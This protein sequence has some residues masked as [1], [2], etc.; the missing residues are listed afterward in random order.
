MD[1]ACK[2]KRA[3]EL[4]LEHCFALLWEP[5]APTARDRLDEQ[6]GRDLARTL[7]AALSPAR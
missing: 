1:A 7:V 4:I 2:S 6:L 3:S 5:Q